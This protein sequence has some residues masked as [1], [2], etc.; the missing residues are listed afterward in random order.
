MLY[1]IR[2]LPGSGKTTLAH[3]LANVVCEADQYMV[4]KHGNYAF[5][6]KRLK[7]CHE[8]CFNAVAAAL[9]SGQI[10]AVSNTFSQHW[11]YNRYI[12]LAQML[13]K[14]FQI[15]VCQGD[16]GSVHNV[17]KETIKAMRERW[18]H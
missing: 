7:E 4:D 1:I 16:W 9:D 12:L 15:I 2:G 10:V 5:D 13:D 8:K 17:P 18:E 6:P 3:K 11:E 14:P